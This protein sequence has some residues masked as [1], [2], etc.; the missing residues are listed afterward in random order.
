MKILQNVMTRCD[1]KIEAM[2]S[3]VVVKNK[4]RRVK[5]LI[6]LCQ[7]TIKLVERRKLK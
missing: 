7:G 6:F 3:D 5:E 1:R 4:G 2:K